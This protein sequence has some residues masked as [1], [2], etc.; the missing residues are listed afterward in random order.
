MENKVA[1]G[2]V[3]KIILP[4]EKGNPEITTAWNFHAQVSD[5]KCAMVDVHLSQGINGPFLLACC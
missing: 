1:V 2:T 5:G 3:W 4:S